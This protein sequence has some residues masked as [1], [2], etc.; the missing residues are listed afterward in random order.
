VK[1]HFSQ[2]ASQYATFR[3]RYPKELYDFIFRH[4]RSFDHAWDAG[5]GN[6]Q[7]A[8]VLAARFSK[9]LATDISAKQLEQAARKENIV[10]EVAGEMTQQSDQSVDLV[11]V[12]QAIHW[13]DRPTFYAEVKRVLKP[14]GVVAVWAYGLLKISPEIDPLISDFYTRVVGLYWD[15]ERKL[16]DDELKSMEFPFKE[17]TAPPFTM[18]FGWT[19]GQLEG[20]LNTWSATQKFV[21]EN[22]ENPVDKLIKRVE[23]KST[24]KEFPVEFPLFLRLG[25]VEQSFQL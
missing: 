16:I 22:S 23:T 9:V 7:A 11:T 5:T 18:R 21:R 10:Y 8:Q 12:A 6:G 1:D 3:P 25:S 19:L 2:N 24:K 20:Y 14:G 4:V 15:P 13:F 17:V